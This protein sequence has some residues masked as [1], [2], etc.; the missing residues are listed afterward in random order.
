VE[1]DRQVLGIHHVLVEP[2]RTSST[3]TFQPS[4]LISST[5]S[6]ILTWYLGT[7]ATLVINRLPDKI[8]LQSFQFFT[9][10]AIVMKKLLVTLLLG[11]VMQATL[12]AQNKPR[13]DPEWVSEKGWWV[14]ESNIH[15]PKKHI[16]YFYNNDGVL[17]YKEKIEGLR[18][19]PAK[20]ATRMQL[21]QVLETTVQ[22]W[23][24]EH[25][26]MENEALVVNSLRGNK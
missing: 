10:K 24:K 18:I 2:R 14:I 11:L 21:K 15:A 20:K 16:V 7:S 13:T 9:V 17:V 1:P 5:V 25:L 8:A 22:A 23:E 4:I 6:D 26:L 3:K 12:F 19:R